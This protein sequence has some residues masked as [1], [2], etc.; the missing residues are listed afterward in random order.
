MFPFF[1]GPVDIVKDGL[2]AP[3]H[4]YVAESDDIGLR[5]E[6]DIYS[7]ITIIQSSTYFLYVFAAG[8]TSCFTSIIGD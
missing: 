7:L 1:N 3:S 4:R 5:H 2:T 8:G 6:V